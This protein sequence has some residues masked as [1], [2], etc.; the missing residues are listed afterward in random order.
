MAR[1]GSVCSAKV[2]L[3]GRR[4]QPAISKH[5]AELED[6]LKSRASGAGDLAPSHILRAEPSSCKQGLPAAQIRRSGSGLVAV[7]APLLT[8]KH[9]LPEILADF[10]HSSSQGRSRRSMS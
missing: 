5:I 8:G 9:L 2:V 7:A 4:G 6:A 10:R 3:G 1:V